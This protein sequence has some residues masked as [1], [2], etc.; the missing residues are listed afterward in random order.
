MPANAADEEN[1]L[2]PIDTSSPRATLQ[3]F[4]EFM[5][6]GFETGVGLVDSYLASSNLYL[7]PEQM[8]TIHG[9][10]HLQESAK[11]SLDL[12]ELPPAIVHETSR[13]LAIQ[14]KEVLDR[15]ALPPVESI[16]D[17]QAMTKAEFKR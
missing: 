3:G 15:I 14:L 4:L 2:R 16:P 9:S 1:P 12:S 5:N 11:R 6:K 8:A 17:A 13:R 7:T 10:I